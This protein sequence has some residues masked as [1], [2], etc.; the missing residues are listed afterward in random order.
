MLAFDAPS[1]EECCAERTRSNIPQQA[2]VLL[3]DPSYV[4]AAR[5]LATRIVREGGDCDDARIAWAWRRV[6]QRPPR[7]EELET[8]MPLLR[9]H[10]A[11]YA[12]DAGAARALITTGLTPAPDDLDPVEV[13][14][15][16]HVA[17]VL[18]NL[19]ET[20]TRN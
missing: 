11:E 5:A 9:L 19:H 4:E 2:L 12:G 13:A 17:R 6:L 3:N 10:R 20:I 8:V 7:V 18:F 14:A 15:W 1:R 16:T